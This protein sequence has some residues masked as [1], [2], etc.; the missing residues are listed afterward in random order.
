[1]AMPAALTIDSFPTELINAVK[2]DALRDA[3]RVERFLRV[4]GFL[5][6]LHYLIRHR[7][8][9]MVDLAAALRLLAWEQAGLDPK[10]VARLP[11]ARTALLNVLLSLKQSSIGLNEAVGSGSLI[12]NVMGAF[13]DHFAWCAGAELHADVTLGEVDEDAILEALAD[14][15]WAH[16]PH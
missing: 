4:L 3:D 1:M 10:A 13:I 16:R 12:Q 7:P 9:F 2:A 8:G 11:S 14:F 15:L 6:I 5:P